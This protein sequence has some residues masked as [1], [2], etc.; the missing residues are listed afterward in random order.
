MG[1][2]GASSGIKSVLSS[3]APLKKI[4][5]VYMESSGWKKGYYKDEVL[6]ASSGSSGEL[7]FNYAKPVSSE[8]TAKTNKANYVTFKLRHGSVN[9]ETFGI[10]WDQV[11]KVTGQTF[12]IKNELKEKNFKWDSTNK[13]WVR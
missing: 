10:N 2:R 3:K 8:K 5:T 9:G 13:C 11:K 6:E 7:V 12:G 4:E 1:G